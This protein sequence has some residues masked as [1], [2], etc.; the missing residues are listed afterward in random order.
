MGKLNGTLFTEENMKRLEANPN[1]LHFSETNITYKPE[2]KL[3]AVQA[4][5]KGLTPVEL[6]IRAGFDLNVIGNKK[7]KNSLKRCRLHVC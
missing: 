2:F 3:A 1:V 5:E 4:R 6:F 7:P